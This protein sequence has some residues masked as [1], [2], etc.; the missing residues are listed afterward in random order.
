MAQVLN[1]SAQMAGRNVYMRW[2]QSHGWIVL[3]RC[4]DR[5]ITTFVKLLHMSLRALSVH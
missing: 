2:M 5:D 3:D 1:D 4:Q